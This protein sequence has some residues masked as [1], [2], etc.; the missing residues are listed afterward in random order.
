MAKQLVVVLRWV[1]RRQGEAGDNVVRARIPHATQCG[2][3]RRRH[4]K[5]RALVLVVGGATQGKGLR[6]PVRDFLRGSVLVVENAVQA[7]QLRAIKGGRE[8][9]ADEAT[10]ADGLALQRGLVGQR[11]GGSCPRRGF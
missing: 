7:V 3:R 1:F 6:V 11:E 9:D 2:I 10:C 5:I 8:I 4:V